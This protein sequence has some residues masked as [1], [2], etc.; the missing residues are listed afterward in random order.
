MYIIIGKENKLD[1]KTGKTEVFYK[2]ESIEK[3]KVLSVEESKIKRYNVVDRL[4]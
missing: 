1:K 4:V 2:L 3:P